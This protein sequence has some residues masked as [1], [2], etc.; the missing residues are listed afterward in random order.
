Q[1]DGEEEIF[2]VVGRVEP[3]PTKSHFLEVHP[4]YMYLVKH[5]RVAIDPF[6]YRYRSRGDLAASPAA[7]ERR[8]F[9]DRLMIIGENVDALIA[10]DLR[11]LHV[12]SHAGGLLPPGRFGKR[13]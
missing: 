4:A 1:L 9:P 13:G 10:G 5:R 6:A 8:P 11:D 12:D 7:S 3:G 2:R